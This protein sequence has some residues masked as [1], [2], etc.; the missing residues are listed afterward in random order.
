MSDKNIEKI[1]AALKSGAPVI[2]AA[3]V[4]AYVL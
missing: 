4:K 2:T 1:A 3:D